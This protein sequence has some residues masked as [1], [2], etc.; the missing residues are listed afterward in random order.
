M[1]GFLAGERDYFNLKGGTGPCVYPAGHLY[2]FSLIFKITGY[3]KTRHVQPLPLLHPSTAIFLYLTNRAAC[4]GEIWIG[5]LV[6][7]A[8]YAATL[9]V[10]FMIYLKTQVVPPVFLSL[11]CLSKRVHSIYVLRLFND[12]VATLI[13]YISTLLLMNRR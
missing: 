7:V 2:M 5:Q 9:G 6:F 12:C 11:L 3:A 10:V 4:S 1:L 13:A 8:L